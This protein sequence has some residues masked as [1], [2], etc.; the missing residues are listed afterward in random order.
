M[1]KVDLLASR[2]LPDFGTLV[3]VFGCVLSGVGEINLIMITLD[4]QPALLPDHDAVY[5]ALAY[6]AV[7]NTMMFAELLKRKA[8][9]SGS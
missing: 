1:S 9:L 8:H 4:I 5:T 7:G 6:L 2:R 3:F